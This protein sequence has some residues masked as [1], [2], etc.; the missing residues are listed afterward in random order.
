MIRF[1]SRLRL[2]SLLVW[3]KV[4]RSS[5]SIFPLYCED[6]SDTLIEWKIR[7]LFDILVIVRLALCARVWSRIPATINNVSCLISPLSDINNL[8]VV[9]KYD[10]LHSSRSDFTETLFS[11]LCLSDHHHTSLTISL[12]GSVMQCLFDP[13]LTQWQCD[14]VLEKII[15]YPRSCCKAHVASDCRVLKET[16]KEYFE[17]FWLFLSKFPSFVLF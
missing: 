2:S 17:F 1:D 15:N 13:P 8:Q 10:E 7:Q 4:R 12:A 16:D 14:N 3:I 6:P 5:T 9:I 11:V